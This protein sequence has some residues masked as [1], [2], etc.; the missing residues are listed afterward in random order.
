MAQ[1]NSMIKKFPFTPILG[2]SVS[3]YDTFS[4]C[5][6]KYFYTYYPKF[7][8]EYAE[9][10]IKELKNLTSEALTIGS[11]VHDVIETLLKR[12]QKST[13]TVDAEKLKKFIAQRVAEY[14]KKY[15]F[16]ETYYQTKAI[17]S[18][19]EFTER[20][21][22]MVMKFLS[23][24]RYQWLCQLPEE[25]KQQWI[26]EPGGFGE[27]RIGELKAYCKVDFMLPVGKDVF[28]LDWKTGKEEVVKHR[29]QLIGYALFAQYHFQNQFE[30]VIPILSYLKEEYAETIPEITNEDISEFE[31]TVQLESDEMKQLCSNVD[32]NI[33]RGIDH[34]PMIDSKLC[35]YCEFRKLCKKD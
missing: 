11:L 13:E 23:T 12:L 29:K 21:F 2:W 8:S 22:D 5:K 25:S 14:C 16:I 1:L 33:P 24:D 27:T 3:R 6:R 15:Q 7:H 18:E 35:G 31:N 26:I 4:T 17:L 28:I 10:E 32:Q 30:K 34:F 9:D 20:I 19:A